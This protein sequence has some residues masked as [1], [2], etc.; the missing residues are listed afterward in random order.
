MAKPIPTGYHTVTPYLTL[1][2]ATR[3][4]Y[5]MGPVDDR[6][7]D[8][9]DE[10]GRQAAVVGGQEHHVGFVEARLAPRMTDR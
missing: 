9:I 2:E 3:G 8:P 7:V 6:E 10:H 5:P 4:R 1:D